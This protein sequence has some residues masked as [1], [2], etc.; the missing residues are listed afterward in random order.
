MTIPKDKVVALVVVA[1]N[2]SAATLFPGNKATAAFLAALV[3][4]PGLMIVWFRETLA[5]TGFARGVLRSSPSGLVGFIGWL[6]LLFF[7]LLF[8]YQIRRSMM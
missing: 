1:A 6:L 2:V 8:V 4:L 5:D 7:P 3:S